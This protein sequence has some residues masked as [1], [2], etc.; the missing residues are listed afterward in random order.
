MESY[1][2]QEIQNIKKIYLSE[3]K[4][5]NSWEL[6]FKD[7]NNDNYK[8][9]IVMLLENIMKNY[10]KN[11]I[12]IDIIDFIMDFGNQNIIN[13]TAQKQFQDTF[14]NLLKSETNAGLEN[15]KKVIYLTQKWAKKFNGNKNLSIFLDNY[16][17]LKN[18]GI[19]FPPGNYIMNTYDKFINK[20]EIENY[21]KSQ[22][23]NE[24]NTENEFSI[25]KQSN[26]GINNNKNNNTNNNNNNN[27]NDKNNNNINNNYQNSDF[28]YNNGGNNFNQNNNFNN[29]NYNC[30]NNYNQ[31]FMNNSNF[32]NNQE[33]IK[34]PFEDDSDNSYQ[35]NNYQQN[36][37]KNYNPNDLEYKNPYDNNNYNGNNNTSNNNNY[38]NNNLD[39]QMLVDVWKSKIKAYNR[40]IDEGKFNSNSINLKDGINDILNNMPSIDDK[41]KECF[42]SNNEE[43]RRNLSHIKF[44]MEQT[45][46]RYQCLQNDKNLDNFYSAFD[47]NSKRYFFVKNSLFK[48]NKQIKKNIPNN[49]VEKENKVLTGL[50]KFGHS[51]KDG[52]FFVGKKIK[53]AAVGGYGYVK[54]KLSDDKESSNKN[55]NNN[56]KYN[57]SGSNYNNN[58][59]FNSN[60]NYNNSNYNNNNNKDNNKNNF[61]GVM[62]FF[63]F[64]NSNNN[65][66]NNNNSSNNN[67]NN[68]YDNDNNKNSGGFLNFFGGNNNNK[69]ETNNY[70][71][72]NS[73]NNSGGFLNFFGGNNN[74]N[75]NETNNYGNNNSSNNS[76]GF[77]NF[78]GGGKN[79]N[80]N[81]NNNSSNNNNSGG[82]LNF[83]GA[84]NKNN[85]NNNNSNNFQKNNNN[86]NNYGSKYESLFRP[87]KK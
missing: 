18:N 37:F 19:I 50:E 39:I 21:K 41:I 1:S 7:I 24:S 28:N 64:N 58:N 43:G 70:G 51:L 26:D 59:N 23:K 31:N 60:N 72:N 75:K 80:N 69:N 46:F 8:E 22:N 15:Q 81:N 45:C 56:S 57:S 32:N 82:F 83:F 3:G 12:T 53:N 73:S 14:I 78:F 2:G 67:Y 87:N 66:N 36:N 71:N 20:I 79:D 42:E 16:N 33:E 49:D 85:N 74:N 13:L 63:G 44:D 6:F 9:K 48:E 52:A 86:N 34:N 47:G 11:G 54:D 38:V 30:N 35:M 84:G 62:G 29:N 5:K 68:N 61:G 10:P 4:N 17:L 65:N 25:F 55:Y 77:L 76:G 27:Y 40:Y